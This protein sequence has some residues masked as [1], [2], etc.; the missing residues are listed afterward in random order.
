[1]YDM[2]VIV[3]IVKVNVC[4]EFVIDVIVMTNSGNICVI[5]VIVSVIN[6]IVNV[7]CICY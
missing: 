7:F 3:V 4:Y 6:V 1:M 2:C 5:H